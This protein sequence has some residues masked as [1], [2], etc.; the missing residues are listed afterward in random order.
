MSVVGAAL[1]PTDLLIYEAQLD[2]SE[3]RPP[4]ARTRMLL[5][6]HRSRS[7]WPRPPQDAWRYFT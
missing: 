4:A 7:V 2:H 5:W 6:R 1:Q 3:S